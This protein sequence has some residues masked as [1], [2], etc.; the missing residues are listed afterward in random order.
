[1]NTIFV[2]SEP[3]AD[4]CFSLSLAIFDMTGIDI[5]S[6]GVSTKAVFNEVNI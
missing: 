3:L 6:N 5:D 1:M 4:W 2:K